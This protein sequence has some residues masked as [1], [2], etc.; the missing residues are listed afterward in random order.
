MA[1]KVQSDLCHTGL[2]NR[3]RQTFFQNVIRHSSQMQIGSSNG[4][5]TIARRIVG[6]RAGGHLEQT[7]QSSSSIMLA[8]IR[9]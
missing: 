8:S 6:R 7:A 2:C 3:G 5:Q 9:G 4:M 1:L